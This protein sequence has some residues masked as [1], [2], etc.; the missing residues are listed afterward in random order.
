MIK[1]TVYEDE[2]SSIG[3]R[4]IPKHAT[5][6][7]LEALG[8]TL[9]FIEIWIKL[10]EE[11]YEVRCGMYKKAMKDMFKHIPLTIIKA[12]SPKQKFQKLITDI[13]GGW[14]VKI[15]LRYYHH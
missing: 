9:N 8:A 7:E 10:L 12:L 3:D 2:E 5:T 15:L 4:L 11:K 1:K 14:Y 13:G 6:G